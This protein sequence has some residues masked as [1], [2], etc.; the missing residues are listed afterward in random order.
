LRPLCGGHDRHHGQPYGPWPHPRTIPDDLSITAESRGK[1][2]TASSTIITLP[3]P[4][5]RGVLR[6]LGTHASR[7]VVEVAPEAG[8]T[9]APHRARS[10]VGNPAMIVLEVPAFPVTHHVQICPSR[11]QTQADI[12]HQRDAKPPGQLLLP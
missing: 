1:R 4:K 8:V 6:K 10:V 12:I 3:N 9:R 2:L 11:K 5:G 7:N